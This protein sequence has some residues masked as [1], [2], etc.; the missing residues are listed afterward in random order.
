[1]YNVC[2]ALLLTVYIVERS[3]YNVYVC[4]ML[5]IIYELFFYLKVEVFEKSV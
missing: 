2:N 1:M 5:F 4:V 3:V